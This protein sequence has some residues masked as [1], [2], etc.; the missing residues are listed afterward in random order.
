MSTTISS[1]SALTKKDL[2]FISRIEK[3]LEKEKANKL[4]YLKSNEN[5]QFN[6][7]MYTSPFS[8]Y[9]KYKNKKY[10]WKSLYNKSKFQFYFKINYSIMMKFI[11]KSLLYSAINLI[12]S[13]SGMYL[14]S[15]SGF[16]KLLDKIWKKI[17]MNFRTV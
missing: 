4:K 15:I 10:L 17:K 6:K 8:S 3:E 1:D 2:E 5:L 14:L 12:L 7:S 11:R 13:A 16:Y 9:M